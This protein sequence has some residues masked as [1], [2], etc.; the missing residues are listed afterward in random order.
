MGLAVLT[1]DFGCKRFLLICM[2]VGPASI[3][4]RQS[5]LATSSG[6]NSKLNAMSRIR[7]ACSSDV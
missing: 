1:N 3:K 2:T 7:C 6:S 5:C 4:A